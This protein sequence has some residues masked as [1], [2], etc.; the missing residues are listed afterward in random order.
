MADY[1]KKLECRTNGFKQNKLRVIYK[2]AE[3][4]KIHYQRPII[5]TTQI[6]MK[7]YKYTNT[8]TLGKK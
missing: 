8:N 3:M 6:Q 4:S 7:I 1:Y 2:F 5:D